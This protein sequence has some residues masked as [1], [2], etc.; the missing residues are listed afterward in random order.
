MKKENESVEKKL[1]KIH[2]IETMKENTVIHCETEE[3]AN[4]I[5]G[6]AHELGYKWNTGD[7]YEDNTEWNTYK[8]TTCYYLFDGSFASYGYF[9][10]RNYNIIPSTQI[11]DLEEK[12]STGWTPAPEDIDAMKKKEKATRHNEGKKRWS[13]V[14]Y[15]SLDPLV[16][17]LEFGAEKYGEFNWQKGL[18]KKEILESMM[19]HL[20]A[21]ID[22]E[23]NDKESGLHHIGHIMCNAMFYEYFNNKYYPDGDIDS[24]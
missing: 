3:E 12:K 21:L 4:R 8:S 24:K 16:E 14:H 23:Q 11:A 15:K 7:N 6:M 18:D 17:V 2:I 5:L 1:E 22:G 9:E 20:A 19:R 13:L 10:V